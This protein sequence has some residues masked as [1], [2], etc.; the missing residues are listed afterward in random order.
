MK[1]G[2]LF[3]EGFFYYFFS[4]GCSAALTKCSGWCAFSSKVLPICSCL[5]Y[6]NKG[7]TTGLTEHLSVST[8]L[9]ILKLPFWASTR[10]H[11]TPR[12][13]CCAHLPLSAA[14]PS[15]DQ[16]EP[17]MPFVDTS[18]VGAVDGWSLKK[19]MRCQHCCT[20][21]RPAVCT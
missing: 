7:A 9:Q 2:R 17:T 10:I 6:Q 11:Y 13:S 15:C 20:L 4:K 8:R 1:R 18:I 16:P 14:A 3:T 21:V 5:N 12:H 19:K